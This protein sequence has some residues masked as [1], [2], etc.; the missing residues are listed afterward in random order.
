MSDKKVYVP[1]EICTISGLYRLVNHK[2]VSKE[3]AEIPL[4]KGE[5]FPPCRNC[6]EKIEWVLVKEAKLGK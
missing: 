1:G 6:T 5:K 3:Q 4:S 2:D